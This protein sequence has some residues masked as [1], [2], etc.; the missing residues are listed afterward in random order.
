MAGRSQRTARVALSV[1]GLVALGLIQA[2]PAQASDAKPQPNWSNPAPA[3]A[4]KDLPGVVPEEARVRKEAADSPNC[5]TGVEYRRW[6]RD[7]ILSSDSL[8]VQVYRCEQGGFTYSG[9]ELPDR[10]WVPG[11]NPYDLPRD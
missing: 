2:L 11:L 3:P 4:F 10:P 6:R 7:S 9:T 5:T 8:P 1:L